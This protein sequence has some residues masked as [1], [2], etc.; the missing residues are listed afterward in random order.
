[1]NKSR[2]DRLVSMKIIECFLDALYLKVNY[3]KYELTEDSFVKELKTLCLK[4]VERWLKAKQN[5]D[6]TCFAV[7]LPKIFKSFSLESDLLYE[8]WNLIIEKAD[9]SEDDKLS[10]LCVIVEIFFRENKFV[11][12]NLF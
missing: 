1:M 5:D 4:V 7:L 9:L 10:A 12:R 11:S 6:W 8:L 2:H 3:L